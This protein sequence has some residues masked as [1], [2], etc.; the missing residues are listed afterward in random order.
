MWFRNLQVYRLT[1]TAAELAGLTAAH[2]SD[3]LRCNAFKPCDDLEI[4]SIGFV[5]PREGFD[6]VYA[7]GRQMLFALCIETKILP[8]S[9]IDDVLKGRAA[10]VE[11]QQGFKPGRKQLRE[12]REQVTDELLPRAFTQ[13]SITRV[14]LNPIGR[15]L[16]IDSATPSKADNVFRMMLR[17]FD[18]LPVEALRTERQPLAAMTDWLAAD[19]APDGFTIDNETELRA[20][21]E[22]SA[23]VKYVRHTLDVDELRRHIAAGKQCTRLAMT[24]NDRIS[25]VLTEALALRRLAPLDILKETGQEG[26]ENERYDSDFTLMSGELSQMLGDVVDALGGYAKTITP[27][28]GPTPPT[29]GTMAAPFTRRT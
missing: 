20:A 19:E 27:A 12:L 1:R 4:Q 26:D 10:E 29:S 14:W 6:L 15:W 7:V 2:M 11:E 18:C 25:F 17:C 9:V 16:A 24:W 13:R 3:S 5:P 28:G 21:G 8:R 23:T 22:S